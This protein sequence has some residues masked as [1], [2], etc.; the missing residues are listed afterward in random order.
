MLSTRG[1]VPVL[2]PRAESRVL[3]PG[4]LGK[5]WMHV[6]ARPL[7]TRGPTLDTSALWL[8]FR[9][10]LRSFVA[11]RIADRADV[12]DMVQWVFLRLHESRGRLRQADRV[13]AWLYRTARRAIVDHYRTQA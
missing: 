6:A 7:P 4:V 9:S 1:A 2:P 3:R 10:R 8:E 5:L 11:R 13:H 12:E